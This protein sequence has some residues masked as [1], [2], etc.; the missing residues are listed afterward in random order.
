M[1]VLRATRRALLSQGRAVTYLLR[2]LFTTAQAAPL[3][4]QCEPG[5]GALAVVDT[6][7][8]LSVASGKLQVAAGG[9]AGDPGVWGAALSRTA[10]RALLATVNSTSGLGYFGWDT[11]QSGD[12]G[13]GGWY[14]SGATARLYEAATPYGLETISNGVDYHF[15]V[16]QRGTG[17]FLLYKLAAASTWTLAW[18]S[19]VNSTAT[20]YPAFAGN[21]FVGTLDDLRVTDLPGA[22]ATDYGI[23]LNRS[24]FTAANGTALT[25]IT[26]E[27]GGAWTAQNAATWEI[28]SNKAQPLSVPG[29]GIRAAATLVSASADVWLEATIRFSTV[30]G[31]GLLV[32]FT[33]VSNLWLV[34]IETTT[35]VLYERNGGTYTSRASASFTPVVATDYRVVVIT[36]GSTI[37]V[38]INNTSYMTYSSATLNQTATTHGVRADGA[39]VTFDDFVI[40]PRTPLVP[41]V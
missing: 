32:R 18:V 21:S 25:A 26:P 31:A 1:P 17:L 36:A 3:G 14:F 29:S 34:N 12:P 28:Q 30:V 19:N 4:R 16:V 10:G 41:N 33:D 23:A 38:F 6:A 35:V 13:A 37:R 11:N 22:W 24:T 39:S 27:A 2:D 15:A 8:K 9:G 40:Y 20:L 5:P 7:S